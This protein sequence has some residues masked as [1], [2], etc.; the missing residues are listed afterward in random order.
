[1]SFVK[2][3]FNNNGILR[4]V[5]NSDWNTSRFLVDFTPIAGYYEFTLHYYV[6][7]SSA[8][9]ALSRVLDST[10]TKSM[11]KKTA[12]FEGSETIKFYADGSQEFRFQLT[13]GTIGAGSSDNALYSLVKIN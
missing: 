5:D 9:C 3:L 8:T 12:S 7:S 4:Y 1:M 2:P 13:G 6:Q 10:S 11:I